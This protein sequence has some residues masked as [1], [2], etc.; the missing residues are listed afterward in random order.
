MLGHTVGG[1]EDEV[2]SDVEIDPFHLPDYFWSSRR[3]ILGMEPLS[4]EI[5]SDN[6][7]NIQK[8]ALGTLIMTVLVLI[9]V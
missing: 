4:E 7:S 3:G 6:R 9:N 8:W 5:T 2:E 1:W